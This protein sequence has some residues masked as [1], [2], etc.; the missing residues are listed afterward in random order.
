MIERRTFFL[1][2]GIFA[3][4]LVTSFIDLRRLDKK[5][6]LRNNGILNSTTR[7]EAGA[8]ILDLEIR[9][10]LQQSAKRPPI[11]SVL[12]KSRK[13]ITGNVSGLLDFAILG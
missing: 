2:L 5:T 4:A 10:P 8:P 12:D 9:L 7:E 11:D 13:K 6:V 1:A 3:T